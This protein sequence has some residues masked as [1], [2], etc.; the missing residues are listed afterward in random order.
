MAADSS[1]LVY[2]LERY[3]VTKDDTENSDNPERAAGSP[4]ASG[5]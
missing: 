3:E 2:K 4:T 1:D 5:D